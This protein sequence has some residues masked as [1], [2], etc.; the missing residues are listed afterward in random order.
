MRHVDPV[1]SLFERVPKTPWLNGEVVFPIRFILPVLSL[2]NSCQADVNGMFPSMKTLYR[3][4][5]L[6]S[7]K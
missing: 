2:G 1:E 5:Q 4:R 3:S 7:G 6:P